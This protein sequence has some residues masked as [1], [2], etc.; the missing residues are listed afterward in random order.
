MSR[1]KRR[2]WVGGGGGVVGG[3]GGVGGGRWANGQP[4]QSVVRK[5]DGE[6]W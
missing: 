2:R 3:V 1:R 5:Q 4:E 6:C